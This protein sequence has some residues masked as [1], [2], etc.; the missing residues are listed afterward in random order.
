MA[1]DVPHI[2]KKMFDVVFKDSWKLSFEKMFKYKTIRPGRL[3]G[4]DQ[5]NNRYYEA[6]PNSLQLRERW[7][8]FGGKKK[9]FN[10]SRIPPEWH[11][12]L[13]RVDEHTPMDKIVFETQKYQVSYKPTALSKMGQNPNYVP[14]NYYNKPVDVPHVKYDKQK[15]TSWDPARKVVAENAV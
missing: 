4:T 13:T 10:A 5:F 11:T 6:P 7:I 12:W 3:V 2:A 8:E 15:Y 9:D 14:S 1:S